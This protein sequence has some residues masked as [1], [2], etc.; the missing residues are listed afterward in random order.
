MTTNQ[1]PVCDRC[2]LADQ[3]HTWLFHDYCRGG[4]CACGHGL[5]KRGK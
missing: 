3:S 2:Q 5:T 4:T 1:A